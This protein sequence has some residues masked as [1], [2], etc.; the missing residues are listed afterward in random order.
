M[1]SSEIRNAQPP[2]SEDLLAMFCGGFLL[3]LSLGLT[4]VNSGLDQQGN[5]TA[6]NPL[7]NYVGKPG[8]WQSAPLDALAEPDAAGQRHFQSGQKVLGVMFLLGLTIGAVP[9][10]GRS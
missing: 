9:W 2:V 3:L 10:L 1:A 6:T 5:F 7:E 4:W 8:Q